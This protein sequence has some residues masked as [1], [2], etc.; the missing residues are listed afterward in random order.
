MVASVPQRTWQRRVRAL[1]A[2]FKLNAFPTA[3]RQG[4]C[5]EAG[6]RRDAIA[7]P[8]LHGRRLARFCRAAAVA[9]CAPRDFRFEWV[10]AIA[11]EATTENILVLHRHATRTK[12]D[13]ARI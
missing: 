3:R 4:Q 11:C 13:N 10:R 1:G 2:G 8:R 9:S 6:A 12:H 5:R 7:P